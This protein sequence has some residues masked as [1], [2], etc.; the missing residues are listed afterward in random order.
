MDT[1]V[2]KESW[3]I[4]S[5][6]GRGIYIYLDV[7]RAL[8]PSILVKVQDDGNCSQYLESYKFLSPE[9]ALISGFFVGSPQNK[10]PP[11]NV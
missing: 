9:L 10:S 4:N 1:W 2:E 7:V 3:D 11:K 5:K 6:P 8:L